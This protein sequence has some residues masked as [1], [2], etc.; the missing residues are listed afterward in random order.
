MLRLLSDAVDMRPYPPSA[1]GSRKNISRACIL[2]SGLFG[3]IR[4]IEYDRISEPSD[5]ARNPTRRIRRD[6]R[7][8]GPA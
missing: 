7:R 3:Q 6:I 5:L 2:W 8:V 1:S 4:R